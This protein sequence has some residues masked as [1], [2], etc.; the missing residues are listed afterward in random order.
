MDDDEPGQNND[1][2]ETEARKDQILLESAALE[3]F[4]ISSGSFCLICH[5]LVDDEV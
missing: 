4:G 3:I 2:S 5:Y 1:G